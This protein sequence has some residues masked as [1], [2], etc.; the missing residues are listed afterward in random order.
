MSRPASTAASPPTERRP[1][2]RSAAARASIP[3]ARLDALAG[4][5]VATIGFVALSAP[6]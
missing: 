2:P 4:T 6:C 3:F 5:F 1:T